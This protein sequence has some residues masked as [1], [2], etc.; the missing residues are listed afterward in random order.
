[1][2][3]RFLRFAYRLAL[4]LGMTVD[5]VLDKHTSHDLAGWQA[6][7]DLEPWGYP[8]E[9]HVAGVLAMLTAVQKLEG[10]DGSRLMGADFFP[11]LDETPEDLARK[12]LA[13]QRALF[14]GLAGVNRNG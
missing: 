13:K 1:M 12:E 14:D 10:I 9:R 2:R 4:H 6:Y 5:E 7:E 3:N 8:W 11:N